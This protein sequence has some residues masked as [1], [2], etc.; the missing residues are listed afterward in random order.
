MSARFT[1][2][3]RLPA[4]IAVSFL[5]VGLTPSVV[6]ADPSPST[7][8]S[9]VVET[10]VVESAQFSDAGPAVE[11]QMSDVVLDQSA[12]MGVL[13]DQAEIDVQE[14]PGVGYV[15]GTAE[16]LAGVESV[17]R[18]E[19]EVTEGSTPIAVDLEY[20]IKTLAGDPISS[21]ALP[22]GPGSLGVK[23]Y[24]SQPCAFLFGDDPGDWMSACETLGYLDAGDG[25]HGYGVRDDDG[26]SA[27]DWF[28]YHQWGTVHPS[29]NGIDSVILEGRKKSFI[30]LA[31]AINGNT[32]FTDYAPNASTCDGALSMGVGFVFNFSGEL[33]TSGTEIDLL[34]D[35]GSFGQHLAIGVH[36]PDSSKGLNYRI[37][38]RIKQGVKPDWYTMNSAKFRVMFTPFTDTLNDVS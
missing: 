3:S 20:S 27:L 29:D 18:I 34:D 15:A 14:A 2:A 11:E 8:T 26:S 33:C 1:Q 9:K 28:T 5:L 10:D 16:S 35:F 32:A 4:V 7:E 21:P 22:V 36:A 38:I 13:V 31:S 24:P 12:D 17:G 37:A 23:F 30:T 19:S 6:R 25:R